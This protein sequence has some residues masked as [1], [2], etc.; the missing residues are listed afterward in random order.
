M[1]VIISILNTIVIVGHRAS[2][3][4]QLD[5]VLEEPAHGIC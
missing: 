2:E 1:V 5:T 3:T 4:S